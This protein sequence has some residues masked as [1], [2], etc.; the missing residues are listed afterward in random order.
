M[1]KLESNTFVNPASTVP[2]V[3]VCAAESS[4]IQ[5]TVAPTPTVIS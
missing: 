5:E 4:L 3:T 2:L 1:N